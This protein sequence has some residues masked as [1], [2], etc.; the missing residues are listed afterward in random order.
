MRVY[1]IYRVITGS[2]GAGDV[3]RSIGRERQMIGSKAR[4]QRGVD[5]DLAVLRYAPDSSAA[6]S[7]VKVVAM[8]E[9]NPGCDSHSFRIR[10]DCA[11]GVYAIDRAIVTRR[12]IELAFSVKGK[13]GRVHQV[14]DERLYVV[15]RVNLIDGNGDLLAASAGKRHIHV[16]F[17]IER[18]IC[19][20]MKIVRNRLSD[21]HFVAIADVSVTVDGHR[22][23]VRAI[24]HTRDQEIFRADDDRALDAT[25]IHF[26][27][28]ELRRLECLTHKSHFTS[29]KR[30][31]GLDR[32]N[33]RIAISVL[34]AQQSVGDAHEV[35]V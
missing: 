1:G 4:L 20:G 34:F 31:G 25:E 15:I 14:G 3:E 9:S 2:G 28:G 24:G 16:A 7:Y 21:F 18:R 33:L 10:A 6:I 11:V 12:D 5:E 17:R 26:R 13:A 8:I 27:P 19:N 29:G 35:S 32:V 23:G 22:A 30:G